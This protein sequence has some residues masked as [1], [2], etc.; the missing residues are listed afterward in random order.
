MIAIEY[1]EP[2]LLTMFPD[3]DLDCELS[4]EVRNARLLSRAIAIAAYCHRNM[5][6]KG[7]K[8]YITHPMRLM[9]RLRTTDNQLMTLA[10]LHDVVEDCG[11][12]IELLKRLGFDQQ[13]LTYLEILSH[14]DDSVPYDQYIE[15]I[16]QHIP[17]TLI[18]LEDLRDNSDITRVKGL[19]E[20]DFIRL[21]K[22]HNAYKYLSERL[23]QMRKPEIKRI[24]DVEDLQVGQYYYC[25]SI[26]FGTTSILQCEYNQ[27]FGW[28]HIDS[29]WATSN[30]SAV[31]TKWEI[32]GP[33]P[34]ID[35]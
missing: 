28:K 7:L 11:V 24:I 10:V 5:V 29:F 15:K 20:K 18:K 9:M 31:F 32:Y 27:T 30:D 26:G 6:D 23:Q 14:L 34:M 8:P 21:Q 16:G 1:I 3:S 2:T 17:T 12:S 35:F 4:D 33:V 25:K 22:Y 19:R 13:T